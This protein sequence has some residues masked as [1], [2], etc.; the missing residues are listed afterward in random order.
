MDYVD[1]DAACQY[2]ITDVI[3]AGSR[4][5]HVL[6]R[7]YDVDVALDQRL[8]EA[9]SDTYGRDAQALA[10]EAYWLYVRLAGPR[11]SEPRPLN[12][13]VL[14]RALILAMTRP[15][16]D[17]CWRD[18][19]AIEAAAAQQ[20][21]RIRGLRSNRR[22]FRRREPSQDELDATAQPYLEA[23]ARFNERWR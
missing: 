22:T 7:V 9:L 3:I 14:R 23:T 19:L 4:A 17:P 21:Q 5:E 12:T 2:P 8:A 20:R 6:A 15:A 1:V 11:Q 18:Y 10:N 13:A 16:D